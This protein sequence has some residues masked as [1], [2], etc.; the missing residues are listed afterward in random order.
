MPHLSLK[1]R[2]VLVM[3][4]YTDCLCHIHARQ[5]FDILL[6]S[7]PSSTCPAVHR[8]HS[9]GQNKPRKKNLACK[10]WPRAAVQRLPNSQAKKPPVQQHAGLRINSQASLS[11]NDISA[12]A[13]EMRRRHLALAKLRPLQQQRPAEPRHLRPREGH[14]RWVGKQ[15]SARYG[16]ARVVRRW[17]W[18][19]SAATNDRMAAEV[20][21]GLRAWLRPGARSALQR[22]SP[23][24]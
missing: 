22:I 21:V 19:G 12:A 8:R 15:K 10:R 23:A 18:C 13:P 17:R 11:A 5:H 9:R 2:C 4:S 3:E 6:P 20:V 16:R 14:Q 1:S 7:D 24:N